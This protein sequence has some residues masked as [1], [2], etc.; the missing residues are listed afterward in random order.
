VKLCIIFYGS[1]ILKAINLA[2]LPKYIEWKGFNPIF[3]LILKINGHIPNHTLG[4]VQ[5]C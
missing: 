5:G 4:G 2:K 3:H 1:L